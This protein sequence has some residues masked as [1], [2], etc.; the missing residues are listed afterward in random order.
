MQIPLEQ[1][2]KDSSAFMRSSVLGALAELDLATT[3]LSLGN[4]AGVDTIATKIA[5]SPR[6]LEVLL[7]ALVA[8]GYFS[9]KGAGVLAKYSVLA[10]FAPFLDSREQASYIPM[11]RHRASLQRHWSR[12]S[13]AVRD[14]K[15]QKECSPSFLGAA[16]DSL[17]FISAMNAIALQLAN[18]T[19][20]ALEKA[21]FFAKLPSSA[22]IL[23][24]G[25]ALG[26]YTESFLRRLPNATVSLFDLPYA[27][28]EAQKHFLASPYEKRVTFLEGDFTKQGFPEG[29][30]L[31]WI[32]AI[33][34][35]LGQEEC[36]DLFQKTFAALSPSGIVAIRDFVM[37]EG[38]IAP[39]DG[40]LFGLNMLVCTAHGRVY[41]FYEIKNCLLAA[42]FEK[43]EHTIDVPSMS[44]V[45][46][47]RKPA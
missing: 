4:A 37:D 26:T 23:D 3:V 28:I 2:E 15:A 29:F 7:D 13:W 30:D 34:H 1:L 32:S 35:Q 41:S 14:G 45:V 12:L 9:K 39:M 18:D 33:I 19:M 46:T 17:S 25:G 24:I 38:K 31:A 27:I 6:G 10:D 20:D 40:T 5:C 47:A 8:L 11:L 44:A 42:G 36:L 22:R 43:V 16:N 21:G